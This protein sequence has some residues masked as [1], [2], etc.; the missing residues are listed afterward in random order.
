MSSL[1]A[2]TS[3]V[4]V[5]TLT[6]GIVLSALALGAPACGS[7]GVSP[8]TDPAGMLDG[9]DAAVELVAPEGGVALSVVEAWST[10]RSVSNRGK[11]RVSVTF[12]MANGANAEPLPLASMLFSVTSDDG[13]EVPALE[14]SKECPTEARLVANAHRRCTIVAE[15]IKGVSPTR[16]RYSMPT[17]GDAGVA[18]RSAEAPIR[19]YRP[20]APCGDICVDLQ[21]DI[22]NCGMC[23]ANLTTPTSDSGRALLCTHGTPTCPTGQSYCPMRRYTSAYCAVLATDRTDCG[24]CGRHVNGGT[25]NGGAPSCSDANEAPCPV[26]NDT[27]GSLSC[28][29]VNSLEL[30]GACAKSCRHIDATKT[31]DEQC[32]QSRCVG[33]VMYRTGSFA[34]CKEACADAGFDIATAAR[35]NPLGTFTCECDGAPH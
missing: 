6:I 11:V 21:T 1:L 23:G 13:L 12:D 14:A 33:L 8:S 5:P 30:C 10:E 16:L 9:G 24:A 22:E 7:A 29:R 19:N 27:S 31:S 3:F 32:K 2:R 26:Q 15:L 25:C 18:S 35:K 17:I 20:C 28:T 34:S 4:R